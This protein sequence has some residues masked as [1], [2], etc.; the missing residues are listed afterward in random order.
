MRTYQ[1]LPAREGLA[2][3]DLNPIL[4]KPL[5]KPAGAPLNPETRPR[6]NRCC[7]RTIP[8]IRILFDDQANA[9]LSPP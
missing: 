5:K 2:L 7:H 1:W 6:S 3:V 4:G 9:G 8:R